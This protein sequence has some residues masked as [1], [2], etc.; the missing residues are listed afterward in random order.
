T[1]VLHDL[2][3]IFLDDRTLL[4]GSPHAESSALTL[5]VQALRRAPQGPL[6]DALAQAGQHLVVGGFNPAGLPRAAVMQGHTIQELQ[7][8]LPLL[9]A[10]SV[11]LTLDLDEEIRLD[12]RG[13]FPDAAAAR[14]AEQAVQDLLTQARTFMMQ[15][16]NELAKEPRENAALITLLK[17]AD[18]ALRGATVKL[19]GGRLQVG[20]RLKTETALPALLAE[21]AGRVDI[22]R[23]R[24]E[25]ANN[26]KQFAIA[27]HNYESTFQPFPQAGFPGNRT[28]NGRR[29]LSGGV[30]ILPFLEQDNVYRQFT[31]DEPWDGPT[32]KRLI[33]QLPKIFEVPGRKAPPGMTYYQVFTGPDAPFEGT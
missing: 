22:A 32:N 13:Q 19:D 7:I 3:V 17:E 15:G 16:R 30:T 21:L 9:K 31:L 24:T 29:L 4:L 18:A 20:V 27:F 28:P 6:D 25:R 26:L 8:L 2:L 12:V 5:L 10:S 14:D 1:F 33:A 11:T 23:T